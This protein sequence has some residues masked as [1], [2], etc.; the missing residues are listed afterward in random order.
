MVQ[1]RRGL[2]MVRRRCLPR[3]CN[4]MSNSSFFPDLFLWV[5]FVRLFLPIPLSPD[6]RRNRICASSTLSTGTM[7]RSY[8]ALLLVGIASAPHPPYPQRGASHG[9]GSG[10]RLRFSR[11][12]ASW[13][14]F[15]PVCISL[16]EYN[17]S[18]PLFQS[19]LEALRG[20]FV[21]FARH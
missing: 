18:S 2:A 6:F 9:S 21:G 13:P 20:S 5:P 1:A 16:E 7:F 17:A 8:S 10:F 11:Q 15:S 14:H 4:R 19:A 3:S 12:M